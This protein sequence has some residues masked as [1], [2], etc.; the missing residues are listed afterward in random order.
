MIVQSFRE[1]NK[2]S[3]NNVEYE[4]NYFTINLWLK[5]IIN[6]L[7]RLYF[8]GTVFGKLKSYWVEYFS[9]SRVYNY[10][11]SNIIPNFYTICCRVY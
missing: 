1:N 7:Y 3:I 2:S 6:L 10:L 4:L 9:T 5:L 11:F 8:T